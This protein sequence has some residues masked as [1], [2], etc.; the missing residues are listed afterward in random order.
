MKAVQLQW[1]WMGLV[2]FPGT[3]SNNCDVF[4]GGDLPH[5]SHLLPTEC[6]G[7][8]E[9]DSSVHNTTQHTIAHVHCKQSNRISICGAAS[10]TCIVWYM[11]LRLFSFSYSTILCKQQHQGCSCT[12]TW[13]SSDRGGAGISK[14]VRPLQIKDHLCMWGGPQQAM[15]SSKSYLRNQNAWVPMQSGQACHEKN[16]PIW[17][18][19][20]TFT[21][22]SN[23]FPNY[24]CNHT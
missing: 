22:I 16:G 6:P 4:S 13:V 1:L 5:K 10:A 7:V 8:H 21:T 12:C 24:R 18:K 19:V 3:L 17:R 2:L 14:V 11:E 20:R 9:S 23:F 15:R